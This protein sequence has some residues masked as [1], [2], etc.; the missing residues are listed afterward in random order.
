[1]PLRHVSARSSRCMGGVHVPVACHNGVDLRTRLHEAGRSRPARHVSRCLLGRSLGL[2]L[3]CQQRQA[4][5][6][7]GVP[8]VRG[9]LVAP[10]RSRGVVPGSTH[11]LSERRSC[12]GAEGEAG[13]AKIVEVDARDASPNPSVLPV[14]VD[15]GRA[16][17]SRPARQQRRLRGSGWQ[18]V[19]VGARAT[20]AG[21]G[22]RTERWLPAL[23]RVMRPPSP[24]TSTT[25]C[26]KRST[27]DSGST[28]PRR[29]PSTSPRRV[30]AQ[31]ASVT[32]VRSST[33]MAAVSP[34]TSARLS[35]GRSGE[36]A[37]QRP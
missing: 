23:G 15:D 18:A 4:R 30:C 19:Q 16:A 29:R 24:A 27:P 13:V 28:P 22:R 34:S 32:K 35:S 26:S 11:H 12:L 1:M 10:A 21:L 33:G 36:Y 6:D 5:R 9:V 31:N 14:V 17:G 3:R 25:C 20:M 2:A 37:C 7:D 8:S